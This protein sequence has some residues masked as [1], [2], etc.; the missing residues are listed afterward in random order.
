MGEKG[1]KTAGMDWTV[2]LLP[3]PVPDQLQIGN[4]GS[5]ALDS[6]ALFG[7][8]G[9]DYWRKNGRRKHIWAVNGDAVRCWRLEGNVNSREEKEWCTYRGVSGNGR[10]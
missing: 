2:H 8:R 5:G 7:I 10:P 1:R 6:L 9:S 4:V 3:V